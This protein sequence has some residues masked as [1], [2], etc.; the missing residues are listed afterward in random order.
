MDDLTVT[1]RSVP[2]GRWLLQ[3][4]EKLISWVK[5]SFKPSKFRAMVLKK[6]KVTD[7]FCFLLDGT[8]IPSITNSQEPG[9][10]L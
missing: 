5:M 3:G 10:G 8:E 1:I 6:G 9:K 7:K 2:E 4:L